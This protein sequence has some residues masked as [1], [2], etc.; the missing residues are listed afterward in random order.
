[1]TDTPGSKRIHPAARMHADE[2]R[3]G[4]MDRREF[5]TRAT[6][7]GVAAP[8]AYGMIGLASPAR[9]QAGI[10]PG[11]TLRI[12]QSVKGMK[13]PRAYDW[14]EIGNQ[15]RGFL[16]YL[17]EYNADGSFRGMLLE[18]WEVNDDAT[19]YT[20]NVRQ[21]AKWNNGDPF[22]A[23]DVVRNI[24]GWCDKGMEANSM[25]SRMGGLIDPETGQARDGAIEKVDETTVKLNLSAP[26]ISVIA[27]M[28]DY[29]AAIT[30][31]SYDGGNP[32]DNGI[33]TGPFRPV[34]LEVGINCVLERIT[35]HE[36]WGTEVY[37][38]PYVDRVEF[39]DYGTDPS[40]WVAAAESEEVDLL[41]ETV[42]DFIDVMDAIGWTRTETVTAATIVFRGNQEAEVDGQKPYSD[43]RVRR[44][45][46]MAADNAVL[47]ELGY[48]GRGEVAA[49]HHVCPIHPAYADIGP[50][51]HDPAGAKALMEEAGMADFEHELITVDD[52]WQ[53]NTGD[54]VAAQLRDAGIPVKRTILPGNTFWNKWTEYPFSATQWNHRPLDVQILTLAYRSGEAWNEAAYS[55]PDFDALIGQA[56]AIADADKRRTVVAEIEQ[57]L[58]DDGVIIQPYWRSLYNHHN[59]TLVN[60]EKH[61]S[62]EIHLYKIGFAA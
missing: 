53:R 44:A 40:A 11:G 32:F 59:G 24:T 18:D 17:V 29:P 12:Q 31:A 22:T 55:N 35:D 54:A 5:L 14:S 58:R 21:G 57:T 28:S 38:G 30:H 4:R 1:M 13:D 37:G 60:A 42:G 46:A 49:N 51:E 43:A 16:E 39:I 27:N 20:L 34:S 23:D 45:L 7:L 25:A 52:D 36:W 41:Y 19:E 47:L 61:P 2:Y 15:S 50:A 62:H 3:A 8:A 26:D 9:A 6:A 56:N 33:G 10:Q 48:S